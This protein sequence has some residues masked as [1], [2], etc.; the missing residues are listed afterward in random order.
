M[1]IHDIFLSMGN[2]DE[3]DPV[4]LTEPPVR[5]L[6]AQVIDGV[7][8]LSVHP[9]DMATNLPGPQEGRSIDVSASSLMSALSVLTAD[10]MAGLPPPWQT[11]HV[12]S[13]SDTG[14]A[15]V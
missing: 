15:Y 12:P 1:P 2:D 5:L 3:D 9:V 7:V 8:T 6:R 11:K 4:P 13:D 10:E 14:G